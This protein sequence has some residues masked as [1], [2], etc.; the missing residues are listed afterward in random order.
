MKYCNIGIPNAAAAC[1][2]GNPA[3]RPGGGDITTVT[4]EPYHTIPAADFYLAG[5]KE[6]SGADEIPVG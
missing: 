6:R 3:K 1:V 5:G 2:G 4:N